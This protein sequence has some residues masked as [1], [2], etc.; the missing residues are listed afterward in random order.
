LAFPVTRGRRV[1][2]AAMK[3]SRQRAPK[4]QGGRA[5]RVRLPLEP[6]GKIPDG[7]QRGASDCPR[8]AE[9][10]E[11]R[12]RIS[13]RASSTNQKSGR[14]RRRRFPLSRTGCASADCQSASGLSVRARPSASAHHHSTSP[15]PPPW[16][17][18]VPDLK[19][20][21]MPPSLSSRCDVNR[22]AVDRG[23]LRAVL[24]Y[25]TR[26]CPIEFM[27]VAPPCHARNAR[28]PRSAA[29]IRT[30]AGDDEAPRPTN[31]P[32]PRARFAR[33]QPPVSTRRA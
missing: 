21:E 9:R 3:I 18:C 29:A 17:C 31:L 10:L 27:S 13:E 7:T 24:Q 19:T 33:P 32:C 8:P 11:T 6:R 20:F 5:F 23:I 22:P 28:L 16:R 12:L 26:R 30:G 15:V 4:Y 25:A 14:T 1:W 2:P